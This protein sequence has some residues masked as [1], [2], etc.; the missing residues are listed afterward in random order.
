M[1]LLKSIPGKA[2]AL[3]AL[4]L[5]FAGSILLAHAGREPLSDVLAKGSVPV[6]RQAAGD[7]R[8]GWMMV[9]RGSLVDAA[10]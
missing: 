1:K 2:L 3:A 8:T 5:V 10:L 6:A 9:P 4:A 7:G